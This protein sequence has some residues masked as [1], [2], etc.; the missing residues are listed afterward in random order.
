VSENAA[1]RTFL[2]GMAELQGGEIV[3]ALA[4]FEAAIRIEQRQGSAPAPRY[5]SYYGV[6]LA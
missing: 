2:K 3:T 1:E 4:L 5:V 6:C